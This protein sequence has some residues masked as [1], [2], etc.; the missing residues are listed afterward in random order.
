MHMEDEKIC[1][2]KKGRYK[3][4]KGGEYQV[5]DFAKNSENPDEM[6]AIYK[7][8]GSDELWVRSC[9]MFNEQ[10]DRDGYTG[11]RFTYIG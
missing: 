1:G 2:V 10:V 8:V 3:H 11:P 4:F 7:H 6:F 5:I 9:K